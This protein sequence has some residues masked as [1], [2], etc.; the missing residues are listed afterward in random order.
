MK[1]LQLAANLKL[2]LEAVSQKIGI[3]AVSGAGKTYT[4]KLLVEELLEHGLWTVVIDPVGVWYGLR[5]SADG[6]KDGY[7][8][9]ILGGEHGD[10]PLDSHRGEVVAR[11]VIDN[12]LSAILDISEWTNAE[13]TRFLTAF[14]N[15]LYRLKKATQPPMMLVLDE[16]D[17]Y[18]PQRAMPGEQVLLGAW[19]KIVRRGRAKGLGFTMITQRG[20]ALNKNVLTQIETLIALRNTSPQD[21]AAIRA[22]VEQ[23]GTKEQT[24]ALLGSLAADF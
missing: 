8:I 9:A 16:A 7:A 12:T 15:E 22:W 3:L 21:S 2:P 10:V 11:F 24:N 19:E 17:Q 4:A 23:H 20:A 1:T 5:S 18:A 6:R 13:Q 14:A